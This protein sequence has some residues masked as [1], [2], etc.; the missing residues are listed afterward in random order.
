M[1][2]INDFI[3]ES[4]LEF[5]DISAEAFREYKFPNGQSLV[6][7][8]PLLINVS[9]SGGHRLFDAQGYSWYVQPKEGWSIKWLAEKG[10]ANFSV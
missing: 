4:G 1:A 2:T 8:N 3:N 7:T 6:I 9:A 10:K 5:K